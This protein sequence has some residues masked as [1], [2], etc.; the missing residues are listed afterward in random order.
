MNGNSQYSSKPSIQALVE[1]FASNQSEDA[2]SRTVTMEQWGI[3]ASYM[4]PFV[5]AASEV[6][7]TQGDKDRILYFVESGSLT[8]HFEDASGRIRLAIVGTGSVLGESGFFSHMPRNA[9]V[10]AATSC[11]MWRMA[12]MSFAE[13]SH[14]Q[15]GATLA[16]VM[17]LAA[18]VC[19]RMKDQR[20]RIAV[21]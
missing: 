11:K 17:A 8:V 2:F 18:I 6:L 13:M 14:R 15:P 19:R 10:Q 21:T 16:L 12:P 20:K 7:I 9:T 4:Q 1:A 5:L 3:M